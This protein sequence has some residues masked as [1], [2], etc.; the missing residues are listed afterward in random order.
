MSGTLAR[1]RGPVRAAAIGALAALALGLHLLAAAFVLP[2][3]AAPANASAAAARLQLVFGPAV[4]ICEQTQ[5]DDASPSLNLHRHVCDDCPLCASAAMALDTGPAARVFTPAGLEP[6]TL[7]PPARTARDAD[8]PFRQ[9]R[10]A[11]RGPP[12]AA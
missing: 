4:V 1:L 9:R 6:G 7:M 8:A 5:P 3:G 2:A 11:P 12:L 10:Q